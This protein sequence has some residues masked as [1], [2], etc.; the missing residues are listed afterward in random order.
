MGVMPA[1]A[2]AIPYPKASHAVLSAFARL[3]EVDI[4]LHELEE[5]GRMIS[6]KL[7]SGLEKL[8]K[9]L[10]VDEEEPVEEIPAEDEPADPEERPLGAEERMRIEVLFR[11]AAVDPAKAFELKRELD[12]L[13]AFKE[14]EDRFLD[15]FRSR[16]D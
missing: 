1:L 16:R 2:S 14:Y 13:S 5:Y 7:N 3:V 9:A 6:Q 11:Q 8:R 12:R 15:L 10:Q 4:D